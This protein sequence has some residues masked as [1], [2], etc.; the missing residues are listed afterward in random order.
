M[1]DSKTGKTRKGKNAFAEDLDAMLGAGDTEQFPELMDDGD[2]ETIDRLLM[3]ENFQDANADIEDGMDEF[4]RMDIADA[5]DKLDIDDDSQWDAVVADLNETDR[6][7]I[8]QESEV[9]EFSDQTGQ[10]SVDQDRLPA[11]ILDA[12]RAKRK[13]PPMPLAEFDISADDEEMAIGLPVLNE[14]T[15]NEK[16]DEII[17][18]ND[19]ITALNED[20]LLDPD[21][22]LAEFDNAFDAAPAKSAADPEPPA[23]ELPVAELPVAEPAAASAAELA[24][25]ALAELAGETVPPSVAAPAAALAESGPRP[26][27]EAFSAPVA[28]QAAIDH[29]AELEQLTN[30]LALAN[31]QLNVLKKQQLALRQEL[32]E[33]AGKSELAGCLE[34]LDSSHTEL[35]KTKRGLDALNNQKPVAAYV[36][37]GVAALALLLGLGLAVQSYIAK[38]QVAEVVQIIGKLQ[39]QTNLTPGAEA[40]DKEMLRKELD[41]LAVA[42]S[43]ASSQIADL[44]KMLSGDSSAAKPG[45]DIGKQVADLSAQTMQLGA[46][47]EQL[48]RKTAAL[49]KGRV[50]AALPAPKPEKKK[51]VAVEENWAVNLIA[52]K[53]DWYAKRKAEE[54]AAKG[55]PA[56]VSKTELKGEDWY[57]LSV[58]GFKGQYEA[59]AYAAR[60]KKSLNLDSVWVARVSAN[61]AH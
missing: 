56:K 19:E 55:V 36:A 47:V 15:K 34:S 23:A 29:I 22:L 57:R 51:P 7:I 48:E 6:H 33:K 53:Q 14:A 20:N 54:Y 61:N 4:D 46:A 41:N 49:E 11:E 3:E 45:G 8:E 44:K 52:F 18:L 40:A 60:V 9:D 12:E 59:A 13:N 5:E 26:E 42:D 37:N 30:Q 38:T 39:E 32:T 43:V 25:A 17:A 58:D 31:T 10:Y 50:L 16:P 21:A 28:V 27:A 1:A 2:E 24:A 35:K